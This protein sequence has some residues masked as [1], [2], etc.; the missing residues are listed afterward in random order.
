MH[1]AVTGYKNPAQPPFKMREG[2]PNH[3]IAE[4]RPTRPLSAGPNDPT[5]QRA[6]QLS[7][8]WY[9]RTRPGYYVACS[10]TGKRRR[11][12]R[13]GITNKGITNKHLI[14]RHR[15]FSPERST[16]DKRAA[17]A[18]RQN[19][20]NDNV[21]HPAA[22]VANCGEHVANT[23]RNVAGYALLSIRTSVFWK[24]VVWGL[25]LAWQVL[26]QHV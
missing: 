14:A 11:R 20:A 23:W 2:C 24:P 13:R 19:T 8:W 10:Y 7:R 3:A 12:R 4:D 18:G 21:H 16:L 22:H 26:W 17:K 15:V 6:L 5:I 9:S 1:D 25:R